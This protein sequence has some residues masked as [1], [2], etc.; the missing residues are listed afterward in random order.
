MDVT[1]IESPQHEP[2]GPGWR[3]GPIAVLIVV[4]VAAAIAISS[5]YLTRMEPPRFLPEGT[6]A[7]DPSP[8]EKPSIAPP[9]GPGPFHGE[10]HREGPDTV[11]PITFPDGTTAEVVFPAWMKL[12]KEYVYPRAYVKG[13]PNECGQQIYFTRSEI[14]GSLIRKGPPLAVFEGVSGDPVA[15]WRGKRW[16]EPHAILAFDFGEWVAALFCEA[17]PEEDA[18]ALSVWA[19]SLTAR[20]TRDGLLLLDPRPPLRFVRGP[21]GPAVGLEISEEPFTLVELTV[22]GCSPAPITLNPGG[23]AEGCFQGGIDVYALGGH[24]FREAIVENLE[25]RKVKP[26]AG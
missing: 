9:A 12:G 4:A 3:P 25:V 23:T 1:D 24:A 18:A 13:G 16:T 15:L 2:D 17:D 26:P 8:R 20:P 7:P 22:S 10:T 19:R 14:V 21:Y 5:V 6:S 11:M